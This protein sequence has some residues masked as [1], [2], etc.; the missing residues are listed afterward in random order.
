VNYNVDSTID[1]STDPNICLRAGKDSVQWSSAAS[2]GRNLK[3]AGFTAAGGSNAAHPFSTNPPFG[4]ATSNT[5]TSPTVST[6]GNPNVCYKFN[7][8][9][10][11]HAAGGIQCW[12]PHIYTSCDSSCSSTAPVPKPKPPSPKPPKP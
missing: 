1:N 12:D 5:V 3:I 10:E 11:V 7:A 6:T 2:K 4:N 8:F 9:I